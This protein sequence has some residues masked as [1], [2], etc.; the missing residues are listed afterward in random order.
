MKFSSPSGGDQFIS[1][2]EMVQFTIQTCFRLLLAEISSYLN[3]YTNSL[4]KISNVFV[5]FWR[6]SVHIKG[7]TEYNEANVK[8]FSSPSGGDQFI[9]VVGEELKIHNHRFSSPSGGDQ[10]ISATI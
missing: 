7:C 1:T 2:K 5:S 4:I 8:E 3:R 6:R 9:S 10:F